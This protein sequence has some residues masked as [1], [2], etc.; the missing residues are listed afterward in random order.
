[1][2]STTTGTMT[3]T[4]SYGVCMVSI[5]RWAYNDPNLLANAQLAQQAQNL[6]SEIYGIYLQTSGEATAVSVGA[7][8]AVQ[9]PTTTQP[10]RRPRST[11]QTQA[12]RQ[13]PP[14]SRQR[15]GAAATR[16]QRRQAATPTP[17]RVRTPAGSLGA[18]DGR[19]LA[20]II[21]SGSPIGVD[22]LRRRVPGMRE[23]IVGTALRHLLD[24]AYITGEPKIGPFTATTAGIN[25]NTKQPTSIGAAR[26][27]RAASPSATEVQPQAAAG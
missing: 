6:Y 7:V 23:N 17:Q 13:R 16:Q 18:S 25:A 14:R 1:M 24:K 20:A 12:Q 2:Q 26:A 4:E 15:T 9:T 22:M 5:G 11:Q 10:R 8:R 3:G 27:R 21:R 19:V